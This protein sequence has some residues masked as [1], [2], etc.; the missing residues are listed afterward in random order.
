[1][2]MLAHAFSGESHTIVA[3]NST[4]PITMQRRKTMKL[5]ALIIRTTLAIPILVCLSQPGTGAAQTQSL[6]EH[7]AALKQSLTQ[8]RASLK[9]Y[10]WIQTPVVNLEGEE[11][12]RVMERCYYGADGGVQKVP[13]TPPTPEAKKRGWRGRI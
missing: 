4:Q 5:T 6:P 12:S 11:K 9:Q 8:S 1:M 3:G 13:L 7:V 10:E 2:P